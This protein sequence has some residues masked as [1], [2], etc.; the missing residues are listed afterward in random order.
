MSHKPEIGWKVFAGVA[1]MAGGFA[2]R[3]AIEF[4]WRKG[5][6]KEPPVNPEDPGVRL[7]DAL[8]W[9]ILMGVGMEVTRV[10]ISRAA[11][12]QWETSTGALPAH[13]IKDLQD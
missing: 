12:R 10:L 1:G 5:T 7:A 3:K 2:A 13:L 6:G 8:G 11:V 9:A 4:A